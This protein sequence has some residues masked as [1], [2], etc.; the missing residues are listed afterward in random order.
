MFKQ[1]VHNELHITK[2]D[3]QE[4][5]R[6]EVEKQVNAMLCGYN[7]TSLETH[8][9]REIQRQV[10]LQLPHDL[11]RDLSKK[12]VGSVNIKIEMQE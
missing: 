2:E 8:V 12:V 6:L 7:C 9:Q 5:I 11:I 1:L 4:M 10:S 3:I